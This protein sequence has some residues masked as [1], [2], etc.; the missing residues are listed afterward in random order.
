MEQVMISDDSDQPVSEVVEEEGFKLSPEGEK[1]AKA[2]AHAIMMRYYFPDNKREH[3]FHE[4]YRKLFETD[5][6]FD[7]TSG[8]VRLATN[9]LEQRKYRV[10]SS[11]FAD[12][13][14]LPGVNTENLRP[15]NP[16]YSTLLI[17]V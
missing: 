11:L 5:M 2:F 8:K 17:N 12:V 13:V 15:V 4:M 7:L 1:M 16:C 3:K 9:K 6:Q 10:S 14:H